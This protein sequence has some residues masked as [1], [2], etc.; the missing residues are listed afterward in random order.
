MKDSRLPAFGRAAHDVQADA[1]DRA[2]L[3]RVSGVIRWTPR[4]TAIRFGP[5][6]V[7]GQT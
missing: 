6:F 4:V 1:F 7:I 5:P 3:G 2:S